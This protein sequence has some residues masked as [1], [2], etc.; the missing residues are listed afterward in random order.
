MD[1]T[2]HIDN[3]EEMKQVVPILL[4]V[5]HSELSHYERVTL[6]ISSIQTAPC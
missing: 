3:A 1:H 5:V 2:Y 4:A 6:K